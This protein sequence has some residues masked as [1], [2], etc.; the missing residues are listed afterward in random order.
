MLHKNVRTVFFSSSLVSIFWG[1]FVPL[2]YKTAKGLD[3]KWHAA[4]NHRVKWKLGCSE[5]TASAHGMPALPTDP[6]ENPF[7]FYL[8]DFLFGC[9]CCIMGLHLTDSSSFF[10]CAHFKIA[11]V[12]VMLF[13]TE[14]TLITFFSL[15][16]MGYKCSVTALVFLSVI[17]F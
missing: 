9:F 10:M 5:D 3:R 17:Y 2:F 12:L 6:P 14:C 1:A 11:I 13:F 7:H 15:T 8:N 16:Y 4:G